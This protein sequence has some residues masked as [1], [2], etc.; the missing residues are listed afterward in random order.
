MRR[1]IRFFFG[2]CKLRPACDDRNGSQDT[3]S[4]TAFRNRLRPCRL[5]VRGVDFG[6]KPCAEVANVSHCPLRPDSSAL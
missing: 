5:N 6:Q 2:F 3:L 1:G 4:S